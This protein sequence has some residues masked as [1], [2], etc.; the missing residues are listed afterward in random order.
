MYS[1]QMNPRGSQNTEA[2]IFPADLFAFV[3]FGRL[4]PVDVHSALEILDTFLLPFDIF[5]MSIKLSD[6]GNF[7]QVLSGT[8]GRMIERLLCA[9]FA[10]HSINA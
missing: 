5:M 3:R 7:A 2:I 6:Y 9:F 8:R 10:Q 4:S 1:M